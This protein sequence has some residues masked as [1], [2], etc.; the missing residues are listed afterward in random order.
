M[1]K[2]SGLILI[3]VVVFVLTGLTHPAVVYAQWKLEFKMVD[4]PLIGQQTNKWCWAAGG[5]MIM[6]SFGV[7]VSQ[8]EQANQRFKSRDCCR[9]KL[10]TRC[11]DRSWPLFKENGFTID[12]TPDCKALSWEQLKGQLAGGKPVGFS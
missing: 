12:K 11:N 10:S 9:N 4:V 8:C 5:E 6:K 7:E 3:L 1:N 2:R